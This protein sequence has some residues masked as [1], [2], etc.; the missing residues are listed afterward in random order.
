MKQPLDPGILHWRSAIAM[1]DGALGT[2]LAVLSVIT[3]GGGLVLWNL[4]EVS[5]SRRA[6]HGEARC[7]GWCE[8]HGYDRAA[9]EGP[10]SEPF[11]VTECY[12]AAPV[13]SDAAL[14]PIPAADAEA[15]TD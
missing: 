1:I 5:A 12:C 9:Y 8:A 15:D 6:A 10:P 13:G 4:G 14:A 11:Q 7:L 3:L 2:A